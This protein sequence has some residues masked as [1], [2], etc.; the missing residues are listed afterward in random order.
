MARTKQLEMHPEKT[1]FVIMGKKEQIIKVEDQIRKNPILFGDFETKKRQNEKYLG[2]K[3]S[4]DGLGKSVED[5]IKLRKGRISAAIYEI[6]GII[7]DYRMQS[8]GGIL[9]AVDLY[10][11]AIIPALLNNSESWT[12]ITESALT[13]LEELQNMFLRLILKVPISTPKLALKWEFGMIG[14]KF[15]VMIRKLTFLNSIKHQDDGSLAKQVLMEQLSHGWPGLAKESEDFCQY[16][17]IKNI[18][19]NEIKISK[20]KNTV[21]SAAKEKCK[22]EMRT[23]MKSGSKL[24][25]LAG[26]EFQLKEYIKEKSIED[27][28]MNFKVQTKMLDFKMNF[29]SSPTY[30]R[31]LWRC[32]SCQT[33]AIESQ[34]HV[35]HCPAYK[36]LRE[37][38]NLGNDK[39]IVEYFRKVL[40]IRENLDLLK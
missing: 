33:G 22:N 14:M 36:K 27:V 30:S 4:E 1:C 2:D 23:E 29:K 37:G 35:L 11:L 31:E 16:L 32:D 15:R 6:R 20:W 28:R 39:D 18:N 17:G 25:H 9:A 5:T 8:I 10:E 7:Q 38:K 21:K 19:S 26:E 24:K 13:T 12:S 40:Q 34:S 3:L